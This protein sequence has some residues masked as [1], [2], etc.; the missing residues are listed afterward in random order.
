MK[1]FKYILLSLIILIVSGCASS[2]KTVPWKVQSDPLGAYVLYQIQRDR[3]DEPNIDWVYLGI[4]PLDIRRTVLSKDL[5]RADAFVIR[6]IKDGYL[7]QKK[8]WTGEQIVKEAKSKGA[9]Y[10]NP[11]LVPST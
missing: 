9:V 4:T 10:W 1:S 3:D 11:R 7:D 5:R 2:V 8:A 6:V